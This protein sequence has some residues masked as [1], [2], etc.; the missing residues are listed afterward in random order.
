[1]KTLPR[2]LPIAV[3]Q[4]RIESLVGRYASGGGSPAVGAPPDWDEQARPGRV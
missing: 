3:V 2:P 4:A 1:M